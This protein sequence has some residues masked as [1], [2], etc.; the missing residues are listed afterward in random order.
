MSG[1]GEPQPRRSHCKLHGMV[2]FGSGCKV[3]FLQTDPFSLSGSKVTCNS[4]K[5]SCWYLIMGLLGGGG[6]SCVIRMVFFHYP[7]SVSC[8]K[9]TDTYR[10][11]FLLGLKMPSNDDSCHSICFDT[12]AAVNT[13]SFLVLDC[14]HSACIISFIEN[15]Y[16]YT[17]SLPP[18]PSTFRACW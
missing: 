6:T 16:S 7:Y 5:V 13:V 15:N 1:A 17:S 11:F 10:A 9:I 4:P 14:F 3:S 8:K 2:C 12:I 18:T